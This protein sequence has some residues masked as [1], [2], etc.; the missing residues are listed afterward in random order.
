MVELRIYKGDRLAR[1][2]LGTFRKGRHFFLW[3][4]RSSGEYR[5]RLACKELRTGRYLRT[6]TS[7]LI[8]VE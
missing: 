6:R 1:R 2:R 3:R 5:V 8:G 7:G 4:P